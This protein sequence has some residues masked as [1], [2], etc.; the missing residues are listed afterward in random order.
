M[1]G[2]TST[3]EIEKQYGFHKASQCAVRKTLIGKQ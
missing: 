2:K 3:S 1:R